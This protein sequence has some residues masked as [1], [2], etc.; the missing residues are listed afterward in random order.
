MAGSPG[1]PP[2][3]QQQQQSQPGMPGLPSPMQQQQGVP[4]QQPPWLG[5]PGDA[6]PAGPAAAAAAAAAAAG[7]GSGYQPGSSSGGDAGGAGRGGSAAATVY[8]LRNNGGAWMSADD[9]NYVLRIQHMS[10][11]SGL[12]YVED[13]YYQVGWAVLCVD[14]ATG[15]TP[16]WLARCCLTVTRSHFA[17]ATFV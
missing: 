11:H 2:F 13:F 1:L 17:A 12:P 16:G 7:F 8:R 14:T 4:R 15:R 6:P 3:M 9:I 5:G 10:T